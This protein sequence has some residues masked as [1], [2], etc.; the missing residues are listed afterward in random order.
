MRLVRLDDL[1]RR[2]QER[3]LFLQ[4]TNRNR[5][6]S[7]LGLVAACLL[8]GGCG[9]VGLT[10][11][12][13][14]ATVEFGESLS[15]YGQLLTDETSYIRS[16]VKLMRVLKVSLPSERSA[17]LF[18]K[19]YCARLGEGLNE[20]RLEKL[21]E[22]GGASQRFGN[23]LAKVAD[24]HSSTAQEKL[25]S[26]AANNFVL[27]ASSVAQGLADVSIA[28]PAVNLLTFVST[29]AY[30]RRLIRG[31]LERSEPAVRDAAARI[32]GEFDS[33]N[34]SSL[35]SFYSKATTQLGDLLE[36]GSSGPANLPAQDRNLVANAYRVV[37]RNR[38]HIRYV[39][40]QQR[41]LAANIVTAYD[42]LV[43]AFN[44]DDSRLENIGRCSEMVFRVDLAFKSLK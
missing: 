5:R 24:I 10:P 27:A 13:R 31:E 4:T 38:D 42:A 37:A 20:P 11:K 15:L 29:D 39:T 1:R 30:R 35:L 18:S 23:S 21:V 6:L 17:D 22:F 26:S 33:D 34:P 19:G 9:I 32:E 25:F 16:E 41:E 3:R 2:G 36:S 44:E 14:A 7:I 8:L 12:Q 28:A 40:S 43:A